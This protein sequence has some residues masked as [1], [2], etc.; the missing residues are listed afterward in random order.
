[1]SELL[2]GLKAKYPNYKIISEPDPECGCKGSGERW[3]KP[4]E[5]WPDGR[6]TPCLCICLSG[7]GRAE[8]VKVFGKAAKKAYDEFK[9]EQSQSDTATEPK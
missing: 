8:C 5:F 3:V 9:A 6:H 4:S 2:D 7:H 1:M